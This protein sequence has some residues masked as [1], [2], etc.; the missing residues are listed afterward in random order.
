MVKITRR[1]VDSVQTGEKDYVMWDDEVAGFGLRVFAS[2]KCSYII[3]Y[4]ARGRSRR[5]TIGP[6]GVWTPEL[7]RQEAKAQLGNVARGEN[8]AEERA[9]DHRAMTIKELC[10][11]YIADM[12]AGLVLGKGD[13]PKKATTVAT[14]TGRIIRHIIPLIG[15]WRVKDLTKAEVNRLMKDIIIGKT[16]ISIKTKKLR[17]RAIVRGGAGTAIRTIG[18]L[19]GIMS[20]AVET[21]IIDQNPTHGLRKP[22]YKVRDDASVKPSIEFWVIFCGAPMATSVYACMRKS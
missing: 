11:Q 1:T 20:Y 4:R 16:R 17:G 13:R 18:L 8:P 10:L 6:H 7:A 12:E 3:Q 15:S 14:D 22:K 2:G 9:L 5:Y 21:G 19:G